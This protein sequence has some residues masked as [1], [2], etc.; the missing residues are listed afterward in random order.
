MNTMDRWIARPRP[1]PRARLRLFCLAHAGGGASAFRGW[2]DVLPPEVEVCPVQLPGRENRLAEPAIMRME[3]L[4]E[5]LSSAVRPYLDL[6]FALFGHSNGALIGFELARRLREQGRAGPVH[7]FA[8][9]RRAPD[10]ASGRAPTSHLPDDEF[11]DDLRQLG[12]LPDALLQHRE[13][14]ALL[15]PTLRADVALNESYAFAEGEPLACPITAYAGAADG[16]VSA[17]QVQAWGRHT[18][19]PFTVRTFPGG[20]FF[21][22]EARAEFLRVLS[23]DLAAAARDLRAD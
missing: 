10:C 7:L 6:P 15:L 21:L 11:L 19:G 2:A 17:E 18:R 22:Q 5:A 23:A 14:V 16:K 13:L 3:P 12:G 4:V 1:N 20:H 9:G 8:S